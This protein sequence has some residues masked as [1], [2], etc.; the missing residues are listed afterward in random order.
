MLI[1]R[2]P[3]QHIS[4]SVEVPIFKIL[5]YLLH[6]HC[7]WKQVHTPI[8]IFLFFCSFSLSIQRFLVLFSLVF[9]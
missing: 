5:V 7:F 8:I 9:L 3:E 2:L 1:E 6:L 4:F